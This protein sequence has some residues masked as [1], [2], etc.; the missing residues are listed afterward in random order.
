MEL[1]HCVLSILMLAVMIWGDQYRRILESLE[2]S[3]D[4][5]S[6]MVYSPDT[7]NYT[8]FKVCIMRQ[9]V[10]GARGVFCGIIVRPFSCI[11]IP[12]QTGDHSISS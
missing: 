9:Q 3:T 12:D 8:D 10:F 6:S 5:V 7:N 4:F 1:R 2:N 11:N